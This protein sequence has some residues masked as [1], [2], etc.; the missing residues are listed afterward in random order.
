MQVIKLLKE[1]KNA[2]SSPIA[3]I[4]PELVQTIIENTSYTNEIIYK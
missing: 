4:T 2:P 1:P 3:K